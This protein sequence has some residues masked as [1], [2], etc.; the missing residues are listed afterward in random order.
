MNI[1]NSV[2]LVTAA[3][4]EPGRGFVAALLNGG[5]RK[6]YAA[7]SDAGAFAGTRIQQLTLNVQNSCDV[8][9]ASEL[10]SD[11]NLLINC[12]EDSA[13]C[14]WSARGNV[15]KPSRFSSTLAMCHAFAPVL[16]TNG[17]GAIVNVLSMNT[18]TAPGGTIYGASKTAA[19]ALT[20][21]VR[22]ALVKQGKQVVGI[23]VGFMGRDPTQGLDSAEP[24][25]ADIALETLI[26]L[27]SG[28]SPVTT[29]AINKD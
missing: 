9:A 13:E 27:N 24:E 1:Q 3:D 26:L 23:H 4:R 10:C 18:P 21:D 14:A 6:V 22:D 8:T 17:G 2:A 7:S 29:S 16:E 25:P 11:V 19:W 12:A 5:A 20:H 15:G 28:R